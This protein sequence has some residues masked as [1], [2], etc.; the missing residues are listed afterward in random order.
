MTQPVRSN[1]T[2]R[3]RLININYLRVRVK[4]IWRK[5]NNFY[6]FYVKKLFLYQTQF[7]ACF[8]KFL[9]NFYYWIKLVWNSLAYRKIYFQ[10]R[11]LT[12]VEEIGRA[13]NSLDQQNSGLL[14]ALQTPFYK[15]YLSK[16]RSNQL[17]LLMWW[18]LFDRTSMSVTLSLGRKKLSFK[19]YK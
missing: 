5:Q 4:W 19:I 6:L 7:E 9:N 14:Q 12:W 11:A 17:S 18:A 2:A 10:I 15:N 13:N 3:K 8:Y 1:F 16:L